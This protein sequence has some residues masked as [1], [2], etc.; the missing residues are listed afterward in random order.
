[1]CW[2]WTAPSAATTSRRRGA[3]AGWR[4]RRRR[5]CLMGDGPHAAGR[6][7]CQRRIKMRFLF[8]PQFVSAADLP[9]QRLLPPGIRRETRSVPSWEAASMRAALVAATLALAFGG[10]I[11]GEEP[12]LRTTLTG[13]Q[14]AVNAVAFAPYR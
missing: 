14:A 9:L 6:P 5:D 11:R 4:G 10:S 13:H 1:R 12:K 8:S 7:H 3:P 2:T